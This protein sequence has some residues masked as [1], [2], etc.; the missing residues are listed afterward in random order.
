MSNEITM[1]SSFFPF[2]QTRYVLRNDVEFTFFFSMILRKNGDFFLLSFKLSSTEMTMDLDFIFLRFYVVFSP[3][4]YYVLRNGRWISYPVQSSPRYCSPTC[5]TFWK[6]RFNFC[7]G[8]I[9]EA[10]APLITT[11]NPA[12]PY[13]PPLTPLSLP[14]P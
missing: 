8:F 11:F 9:A 5:G 2:F 10:A 4:S 6:F 14:L 3:Q 7:Y 1:I 12:L 13:P